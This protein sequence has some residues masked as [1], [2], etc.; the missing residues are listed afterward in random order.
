MQ[1]MDG[2]DLQVVG[3]HAETLKTMNNLAYIHKTKGNLE[4]AE[5]LLTQVVDGQMA[6][7]GERHK[8]TLS[9]MATLAD[10]YWEQGKWR[11]A[12]VLLKQAVNG[13]ERVLGENNALLV[14]NRRQL[15]LRDQLICEMDGT[16]LSFAHISYF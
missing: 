14:H 10:I 16:E 7:H 13:M 15:I 9:S 11:D 6:T 4:E 2:R 3:Y 8:Y 5:R 1:A 12:K